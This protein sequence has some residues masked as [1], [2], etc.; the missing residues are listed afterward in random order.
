MDTATPSSVYSP[1]LD[2]SY[3]IMNEEIAEPIQIVVQDHSIN[4]KSSKHN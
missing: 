2:K 3:A 4:T 1:F